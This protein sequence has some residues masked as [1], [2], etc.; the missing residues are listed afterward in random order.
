[1]KTERRMKKLDEEAVGLGRVGG[2]GSAFSGAV[3]Y[4]GPAPP[5][6]TYPG[7]IAPEKDELQ[8]HAP[9]H[10]GV[11]PGEAEGPED[12]IHRAQWQWQEHE[13]VSR[14]PGWGW[15]GAPLPSAGSHSFA[16]FSLQE[17]HHQVKLPS[18]LSPADVMLNKVPSLFFLLGCAAV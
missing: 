6:L 18:S 2:G 14:R 1:M 8:R 15:G 12:T 3:G 4:A 16:L 13:C 7:P 9:G 17:H 10:C 11:A 5:L